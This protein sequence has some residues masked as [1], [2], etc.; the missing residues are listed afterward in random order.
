[1]F[2]KQFWPM[3]LIFVGLILALTACGDNNAATQSSSNVLGS[4]QAGQGTIP[5]RDD[6]RI[7]GTAGSGMKQGGTAAVE[8][9][10]MKTPS[11]VGGPSTGGMMQMPTYNGASQVTLTASQQGQIVRGIDTLSTLVNQPTTTFYRVSGSTDAKPIND[12]YRTALV[13]Q[14]WMERT[15][16]MASQYTRLSFQGNNPIVFTKGDQV[17]LVAVSTPLTAEVISATNLSQQF[18][19]GEIAVMTFVGQP[20]VKF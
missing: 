17:M 5:S 11:T 18:K 1:M 6:G 16:D 10:G 9:T 3:A 2:K 12:F 8:D 19:A 15:G 14:G 20:K 7:V 4:P 13:N